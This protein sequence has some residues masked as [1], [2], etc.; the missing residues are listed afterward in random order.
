MYEEEL[1]VEE[2]DVGELDVVERDTDCEEL[3]STEAEVG[4]DVATSSTL[5]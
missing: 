4:N 5:E 1:D 3:V 2:L